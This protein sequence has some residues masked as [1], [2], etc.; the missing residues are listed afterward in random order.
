MFIRVKNIRKKGKTKTYKYAYIVSNKWRKTRKEAK[1]KVKKYLGRV[2]FF[3][4]AEDKDFFGFYSITDVAGYVKGNDKKKIVSDMVRFE[5]L[6]HG[7]KEDGGFLV[8][9]SIYFDKRNNELFVGEVTNSENANEKEINN[10]TIDKKNINNEMKN[11][12]K[13]IIN[14]K[15]IENEINEKYINDENINE[16]EKSISNNQKSINIK[17]KKI[18]IAMNEGFFCN[19][20]IKTLF[21]NFYGTE[22]EVGLKLANAFVEAGLK[23]PEEIFIGVFEKVI[24]K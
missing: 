17:N 21:G 10:D 20:T 9:G 12:N 4:K 23:V 2:Y 14:E 13:L 15:M 18:V 16:N 3:D 6:N 19:E 24:S 8:N 1:Q 7:F 22:K 5:L 11:D